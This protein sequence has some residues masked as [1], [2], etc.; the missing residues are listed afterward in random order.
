[1]K[2]RTRRL[3]AILAIALTLPFAGMA[4]YASVNPCSIQESSGAASMSEKGCCAERQLPCGTASKDCPASTC[5]CA[6]GG[7]Q[8][9][10]LEPTAAAVLTFATFAFLVSSPVA[11]LLTATSPDGQWRPPRSP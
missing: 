4:S 10:A 2:S 1:M 6:Q 5:G 3:I 8:S 9:Q 7:V 11:T